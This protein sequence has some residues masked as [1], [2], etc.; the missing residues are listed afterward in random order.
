MVSN[1]SGNVVLGQFSSGSTSL[2][3]VTNVAV[4]NPLAAISFSIRCR[5]YLLSGGVQYDI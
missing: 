5:F 2:L 3:R 1:T 4:N